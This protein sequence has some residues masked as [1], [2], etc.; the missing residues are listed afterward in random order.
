MDLVRALRELLVDAEMR[1]QLG[2]QGRQAVLDH[3]SAER[4]ARDTLEV[5][6]GLTSGALT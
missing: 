2:D 4:M 1:R 5:Y 6:R 3:F